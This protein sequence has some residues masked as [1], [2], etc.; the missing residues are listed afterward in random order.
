MINKEWE[1]MKCLYCNNNNTGGIHEPHC[2]LHPNNR[3]TSVLAKHKPI[4]Q[5]LVENEQLKER[6]E[7]LKRV[8]LSNIA[9]LESYEKQIDILKQDI[10]T[11]NKIISEMAKR[12]FLV[13]YS[14]FNDERTEKE[15]IKQFIKEVE[16]G[17]V[18]CI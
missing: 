18:K 9:I 16:K 17:D 3:S 8:E 14:E 6:N 5:I 2:P 12:M 13:N 4:L 15:I 10:V 7:Q 11:K 1:R